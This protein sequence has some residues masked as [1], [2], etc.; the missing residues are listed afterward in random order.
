MN[1]YFRLLKYTDFLFCFVNGV[2]ISFK[3]NF[4]EIKVVL[5]Q[6]AMHSLF[7]VN[8]FLA[9]FEF[10]EM[11]AKCLAKHCLPTLL[12]RT[13]VRIKIIFTHKTIDSRLKMISCS[14][15]HVH[16]YPI[17]EVAIKMENNH[18]KRHSHLQ[19]A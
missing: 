12:W 15:R 7:L 11:N 2:K 3:M 9:L 17:N 14:T 10:L 16:V 8:F 5:K 1:R 4:I 18:S 13:K 19:K 6:L